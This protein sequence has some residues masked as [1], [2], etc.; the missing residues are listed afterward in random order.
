MDEVRVLSLSLSLS[1]SPV[2]AVRVGGADA[3]PGRAVLRVAGLH[4][5]DSDVLGDAGLGGNGEA[6][7]AAMV[8]QW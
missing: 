6:S 3:A 7:H 5:K 4:P 1:L 2:E 8:W